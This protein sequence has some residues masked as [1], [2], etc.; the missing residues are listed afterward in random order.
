MAE[1][2]SFDVV[3]KV[4]MFELVNAVN[5]AKKELSQRFDFKGSKSQI[6]LENEEIVIVADDDFKLKSV[7]DIFASKLAKR[8]VP[9]KA[10]N[11]GKAEQSFSGTLR[12]VISVKQG[13]PQEKAKEMVKL[14]K[15]SG[16]RVHSQIQE[17]QV[18]IFGK[19]KDDLQV[20]IQM[21]REKDFDLPLQ[22]INYR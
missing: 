4:E 6:D 7:V 14:I 11:F 8:K 10:F 18:R 1:E 13:I 19:N 9:L 12:Q 20:V 5:M 15:N 17:D 21:L 16:V 22:F 3:S 2:H